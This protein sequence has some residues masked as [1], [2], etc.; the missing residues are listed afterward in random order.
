MTV[1]RAPSGLAGRQALAELAAMLREVTGEDERWA[2]AITPASRLEADLRLESVELASLGELLRGRYG[3][4]ADL[5]AFFAELDLDQIIA[6]TAGDL[7]ARMLE[8]S[9]H[10]GGKA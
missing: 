9:G 7:V 3:E 6:L 1:P 5:L 4:Q 8:W 2:A 10:A